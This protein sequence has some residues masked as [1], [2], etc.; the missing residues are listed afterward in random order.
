MSLAGGYTVGDRVVCGGR[1]GTV[2]GGPARAACIR[3]SVAVRYDDG[4]IADERVAGLELLVEEQY[5]DEEEQVPMPSPPATLQDQPTQQQLASDSMWGQRSVPLTTDYEDEPLQ[6]ASE[7]QLPEEYTNG[8]TLRE[9]LEAPDS[10]ESPEDGRYASQDAPGFSAEEAV[11]S[12]RDKIYRN[13]KDLQSAFRALDRSNNGYVSRADFF[14]A[15]GDI[16][17]AN[18]FTEDDIY[19]V[20]DHFDLNKDGFMSYEEFVQVV[21]GGLQGQDV[22]APVD[23]PEPVARDLMDDPILVSSVDKGIQKFKIVVDQRYSAIREAF[24]KMDRERKGV[25]SPQNFAM[26]LLAHGVTMSTDELELAYT[27]FDREGKGVITY[28][29]FCTV[30]TQRFQFGAHLDR[31]MFK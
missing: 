13:Y 24:L 25:L 2:V 22:E 19:E 12:V 21:E 18:G 14:Q 1:T 20:A 23:Q 5:D 16:F 8:D 10:P 28:T 15:M 26:A 4:R 6:A 17:L 11:Q 9:P 7:E 27:A 3:L 31:Q 29:D 30:M